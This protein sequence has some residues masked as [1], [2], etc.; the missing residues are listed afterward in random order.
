MFVSFT[1]FLALHIIFHVPGGISDVRPKSEVCNYT[2]DICTNLMEVMPMASDM[3]T[4]VSFVIFSLM[5]LLPAISTVVM[6]P[7]HFFLAMQGR[8]ISYSN[9]LKQNSSPLESLMVPTIP[10]EVG[11]N[12]YVNCPPIAPDSHRRSLIH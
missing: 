8:S 12:S 2:W 11:M 10:I 4:I 6:I 3:V 5:K 1:K 9:S 7:L